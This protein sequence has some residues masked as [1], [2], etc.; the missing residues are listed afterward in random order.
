M[1]NWKTS[2]AGIIAGGCQLLDGLVPGISSIC[3]A[4]TAIAL[5]CM[6]LF[7]KDYDS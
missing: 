3:D 6:G 1:N 4:V 7:A 5:F 2:V